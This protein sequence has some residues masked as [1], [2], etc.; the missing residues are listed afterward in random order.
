MAVY[1]WNDRRLAATPKAV[2]QQR[3]AC[4]E[5]HCGQFSISISN[6]SVGLTVRFVSAEEFRVFLERGEVSQSTPAAT[7]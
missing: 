2:M 4:E 5:Q 7:S 6:D 3:S 1:F